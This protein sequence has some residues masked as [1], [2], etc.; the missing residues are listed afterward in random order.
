MDRSSF[1]HRIGAVIARA[2]L[3]L[4]LGLL[5]WA[6]VGLVE[7]FAHSVPWTAVTNPLFPPWL[8]LLHWGSML[9]ASLVLSIGYLTRWPYTPWAMIPAYAAMAAVCAIETM[10]F[11]AHDLRHV[12]MAIEYAAYAIVLYLLHTLPAFTDR[13]S[14][15]RVRHT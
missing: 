8:L 13:F 3:I 10:G 4:H 12:A 1:P 7:W 2:L 5:M 9:A 15:T 14:A 6:V 11:L